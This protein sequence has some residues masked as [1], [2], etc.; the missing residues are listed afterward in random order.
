MPSL[1]LAVNQQPSWTCSTSRYTTI[2]ISKWKVWLSLNLTGYRARSWRTWVRHVRFTFD[3]AFRRM[4]E[5]SPTASECASVWVFENCNSFGAHTVSAS[6]LHT[7][8][9][10]SKSSRARFLLGKPRLLL[11]FMLQGVPH[12]LDQRP[13]AEQRRRRRRQRRLLHSSHR[14]HTVTAQKQVVGRWTRQMIACHSTS[15]ST[16]T[17][18]SEYPALSFALLQLSLSSAAAAAA[19]MFFAPD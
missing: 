7:V 18:T 3:R 11:W 14:W 16:S 8:C 17:A 5:W 4:P 9:A 13:M 15:T 10:C 12:G 2:F 1:E 19:M 6:E